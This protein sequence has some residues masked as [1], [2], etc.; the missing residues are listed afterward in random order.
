MKT[1]E[2]TGAD[3][4]LWVAKA[5]GWR[6]EH[7]DGGPVCYGPSGY[8]GSFTEY[9]YRP[10]LKWEQGGPLIAQF[11]IELDRDKRK[12]WSAHIRE[13]VGSWRYIAGAEGDTPLEA[14]CRAVVEMAFGEDVPDEAA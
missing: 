2:L 8:V 3:L 6:I 13:W 12:V 10:D 7:E 1:S 11:N 9:G 14:V 4:A 5:K